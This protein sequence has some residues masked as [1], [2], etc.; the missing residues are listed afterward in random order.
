M[1]FILFKTANI[2]T[3]SY[4]HNIEV[5][6]DISLW[7]MLLMWENEPAFFFGV[8]KRLVKEF[9]VQALIYVQ[10]IIQTT[11]DFLDWNLVFQICYKS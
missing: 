1:L 7:S 6:K 10:E 9:S 2:S 5:I 4:H 11:H 3:I 8:G